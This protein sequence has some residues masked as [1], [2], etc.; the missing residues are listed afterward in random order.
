[1][2]YRPGMLGAIVAPTPLQGAMSETGTY[3]NITVRLTIDSSLA[4]PDGATDEILMDVYVGG[5]AMRPE[6]GVVV[7]G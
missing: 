7:Q 4:G 6:F 1:M 5:Q 2:Y 3:E